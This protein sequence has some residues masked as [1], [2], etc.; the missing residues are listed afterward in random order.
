MITRKTLTFD[1]PLLRDLE[2]P[3]FEATGAPDGPR[4]TLI[5]GIHGC[6]YSSIAAATRF[7]RELDTAQL[8]GS[9][10]CVPIVSMES[11]LKRSP[12]VVPVVGSKT[13]LICAELATTH[14]WLVW[15]DAFGSQPYESTG[16]YGAPPPPKESRQV[17]L[18]SGL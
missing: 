12:F 7:M 17:W 15:F 2:H 6:E 13:W 11:Y 9:I 1:H 14:S 18:P 3:C 8:T 16:V 5:A 4:L 10:T